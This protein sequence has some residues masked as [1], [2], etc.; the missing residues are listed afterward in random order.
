MPDLVVVV[1]S[2]GRPEAAQELAESFEQTC[3][4]DTSLLIAVD[5]DDPLLEDYTTPPPR[6]RQVTVLTQFTKTMNEALNRAACFLMTPAGSPFA[7][8][9][10]GD[11]HRPRTR[12]WDEQYLA[13]LRE[14]GTGLVYGDDLLQGERLPTQVAMTSDIVRALGYMAPPEL[15]H[16][17][18]DNFWVS[19][20][21]TADCIRYLPEVVVEHVHPAAGK[22]KWDANYNRVNNSTTFEHDRLAFEVYAADRFDA[23]VAK[24]KALRAAHV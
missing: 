3:T 6:F 16:M 7:I 4:A 9:F 10:M 8:A 21:R 5:D 15:N 17:Y 22:A 12:G 14:L 11:D 18:V 19:L 2:R 13:A 20:G 1:P 23:D 24:V